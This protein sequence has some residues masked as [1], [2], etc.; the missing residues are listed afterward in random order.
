MTP[1]ELE[2]DRRAFHDDKLP[3]IAKRI[4]ATQAACQ[5]KKRDCN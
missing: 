3:G 1:N 2:D 5:K 4:K